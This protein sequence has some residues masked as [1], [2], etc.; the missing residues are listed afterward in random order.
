MLGVDKLD[1]LISYYSF[2]HKSVKWWRK[3]FFWLI[4]VAV[5]NSYVIHKENREKN[6]EKPLTHLAY[7]RSLIDV[8]TEPLRSIPRCPSGPRVQPTEERLQDKQHY[9][10]KE[11]KRTDC[12]VCSDRSGQRHLTHFRCSTCKDSPP[13]CPTECFKKYHTQRNYRIM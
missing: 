4:E 5:V 13:L 2:T 10:K 12:I 9:L 8:L 3:V 1:Q 11:E 7:R 6:K